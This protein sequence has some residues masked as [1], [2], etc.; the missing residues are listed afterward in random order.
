VAPAIVGVERTA[1]PNGR[2][3]VVGS[4]WMNGLASHPGPGLA[5]SVASRAEGSSHQ[6]PAPREGRL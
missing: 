2:G 6:G 1:T 3:Q 4:G 5:M